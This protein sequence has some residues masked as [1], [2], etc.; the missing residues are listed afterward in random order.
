[1]SAIGDYYV[2]YH[3]A[4]VDRVS[5]V[6]L[7]LY[8]QMR[9]RT[10]AA[11]LYSGVSQ[12]TKQEYANILNALFNQRSDHAKVDPATRQRV[13]SLVETSVNTE[14]RKAFNTDWE[15][16]V[17]NG[18]T[19]GLTF[20]N[21]YQTFE[22]SQYMSNAEFTRLQSTVQNIINELNSNT[23]FNGVVGVGVLQNKITQLKKAL[24]ALQNHT[25]IKIT[26]IKGPYRNLWSKE[27]SKNQHGVWGVELNA[28]DRSLITEINNLITLYN[29]A[30]LMSSAQGA[31][32]EDLT[33]AAGE[34]LMGQTVQI[35][36]HKLEEP[37]LQMKTGRYGSVSL[38]RGWLLDGM[39][40]EV[41]AQ[42]RLKKAMEKHKSRF[43]DMTITTYGTSQQKID[44]IIT[45][46]DL[47]NNPVQ[48]ALSVKNYNLQRALAVVSGTNMLYL[49]QDEDSNFLYQ[50]YN[51]M[52]DRKGA[53]DMSW[54][55]QNKNRDAQKRGFFYRSRL[56][57]EKKA[58]EYLRQE[59]REA[60]LAAQLLA[61][62]KATSGSTFMRMGTNLLVINDNVSKTIKVIEMGDVIYYLTQQLAKGVRFNELFESEY[63]MGFDHFTPY[64]N[65][66]GVTKEERLGKFLNAVHRHKV[67][68]KIKPKGIES[69]ASAGYVIST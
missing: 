65:S 53:H 33:V 22:Q 67:S 45:M 2:H 1:M 60:Q 36:N 57:K 47:N 27:L 15:R 52:A 31:M 51:I 6:S 3:A 54:G 48:V 62:A 14:F 19:S 12:A 41:W 13:Q 16:G 34:L 28:A 5:G 11:D 7:L 38:Q 49:L 37:L 50:Y 64:A 55:Q 42:T 66:W 39:P 26:D 69:L 68:L 18:I 10:L 56:E 63:N 59:R 8:S 46:P 58:I 32:F 21:S 24:T 40:A 44:S 23:A 29:G 20:K 35:I 9:T 25:K 17:V 43:G 30:S 4:N 61:I